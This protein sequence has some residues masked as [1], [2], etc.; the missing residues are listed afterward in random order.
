M[1]KLFFYLT[2]L[3]PLIVIGQQQQQVTTISFNPFQ[4]IDN[5]DKELLDD[6]YFQVN[7]NNN[8]YFNLVTKE[9]KSTYRYSKLLS[10]ARNRALVVQDYYLSEIGVDPESVKIQ[11]GGSY[12][13]VWLRKPKSVYTASGQVVLDEN[14]KQCYEYLPNIGKTIYSENGNTYT[15]SS[16]AFET[17]DGKLITSGVVNV[18]LWEFSDKKSLVQANL[19]THANNKMLETAGSFYIEASL[20]GVP[21]QLIDGVNYQV[22]LPANTA[23][24]DMFTYYGYTKDGIIDWEVDQ[25]EPVS[26]N[27]PISSPVVEVEQIWT[28][29]EYG[30]NV[31]LD[32]AYYEGEEVFYELTAGKLGWINC[33]RFYDVKNTTTLAIKVDTKEPIAVRIVFRDIESVLP[34]YSSSNSKQLYNASGIPSGEKVLLLAYSLKDDKALVG[35]KEVIL[36]DKKMETL[37]L[38]ETNKRGLERVFSEMLY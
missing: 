35:Y 19:T 30:D 24:N 18:C 28:E 8:H 17:L 21:V 9:E 31:A 25:T 12:P 16:N 34:C 33:D 1:K 5:T 38:E 29:D 22:K 20:N 13:S 10:L 4:A 32:R 26:L 11:Y 27:E 36:G 23:H 6:I 14:N 37:S 15:F 3:F 7:D 2:L